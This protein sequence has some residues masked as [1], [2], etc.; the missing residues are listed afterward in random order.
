MCIRDS[1][2]WAAGTPDDFYSEDALEMLPNGSWNDI[3]TWRFGWNEGFV[4]EF[5]D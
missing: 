5:D 1:T 3:W 4:C 2:N